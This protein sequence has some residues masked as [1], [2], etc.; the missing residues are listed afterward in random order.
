MKNKKNKKD[1]TP[2]TNKPLKKFGVANWLTVL[3]MVLMIPFIAL[4]S[5]AF[6][7]MVRFGGTFWY[8]KITLVG[9]Q[10]YK[11][12][13]SAIYWVSVTIFIL[14]MITDFVDGHIA[15]KTKTVSQFG[16]IFD[17]IADKIATTLM[18]IFLSVMNY[19]YLPLAILFIL[20][21]ILVDGARVYAVK[22]DI[23]VA[24]SWWGKVKTIIVSFALIT[25]AFSA[26]WMV[27]ETKEGSGEWIAN[28]LFILYVNI[29][30][31]IGLVFSWVSGIIYLSKY[32]KG[33]SKQYNIDISEQKAKEE[34]EK[35]TSDSIQIPTDSNIETEI[36]IPE[37]QNENNQI[38]NSQRIE[39]EDPFFE[40]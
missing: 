38:S 29:P 37:Q 13:L 14:A 36:E 1:M 16:K 21:D 15:R 31:I 4:M 26:P 30:L 12:G 27:K 25:V 39:N 7:I 5:S 35:M 9:D 3:R 19:S 22:K 24:S 32:L 2:N 10:T 33:I 11:V 18:L 40:S 23:K 6:I 34:L 17:P 8:D 28:D 20:R